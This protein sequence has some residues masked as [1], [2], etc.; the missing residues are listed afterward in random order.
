V[1]KILIIDNDPDVAFYLK[2]FL[3]DHDCSVL[4]AH[5]DDTGLTN[6]REEHPD[7]ICLDIMMPKRS[8]VILYKEL[9]RDKKLRGI[10]VI[11]VSGLES[12]YSIQ[13]QQFRRL[14]P[15][16]RTPEP[17]AFLEKPINPSDLIGFLSRT[18]D[19][20]NGE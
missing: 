19:P 16:P 20:L 5:D 17:M 9:K 10:P 8:G 14:I 11:V 15:D 3:E 12:A 6:A 2:T 13:G 7:L 1:K 18:A 4:T